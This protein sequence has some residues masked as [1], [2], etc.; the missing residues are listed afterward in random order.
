MYNPPILIVGEAPGEQEE[1]TGLPFVGESGKEL[2]KMLEEAGVDREKCVITNV[3]SIRPPKNDIKHFFT[4]K[5]T[6][7]KEKG[8]WF[9]VNGRYCNMALALGVTALQQQVEVLKPRM[10]IA[11]GDIA[12]WALTGK[13]GI[14]S[15]RGSMLQTE[16]GWLIPTYHPAAVLRMWTWRPIAVFDLRRAM[17]IYQ[18]TSF[19][20]PTY[21]FIIRPTYQQVL[22]F[23]SNILSLA[24]KNKDKTFDTS[25]DLETEGGM[26]SCLGIATSTLDA[27][28][29][30]FNEPGAGSYWNK[31][32]EFVIWQLIKAIVECANIHRIGQ[33]WFGYDIQYILKYWALWFPVHHDTMTM[34]HII[35]PGIPKGLD[36][37]SSMYCKY[38]VYWKDEGKVRDTKLGVDEFWTYN[39]KDA[40]TTWEIKQAL[41]PVIEK[42]GLMGVYNFQIKLASHAAKSSARGMLVNKALRNEYSLKL[43][44]LIQEAEN[45][46]LR[47]TGIGSLA[48]N[49][50]SPWYASPKQQHVLFYD[51]LQLPK[52]FNKKTKK[53]S[54]DD[55]AITAL[56]KKVPWL[57]PLL[58]TLLEYRS[59]QIFYNVVNSKLRNGRIHTTLQTAGPESFRL[60]SYEDP[61]GY[62]TNMQNQSKGN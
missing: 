23:L 21:N 14:M 62:G 49:K 55:A 18:D 60:S 11:L 2:T 24:N 9:E 41:L 17:T 1:R 39:C 15:W 13:S 42:Q 5:T 44:G 31:E 53:V 59:L 27:I 51:I 22:E 46:L 38:H 3:C 43:I 19:T 47:M 50:K 30:P 34:Q 6:Y 12:L 32:Q 33:N 8:K 25:W 54:A 61:F 7:T 37:L 40:V 20:F 52:Q 58:D 16:H 29:I 28:C 26:I 4:T 35:F 56:R 45:T 57:I 36:F 10:I 48:K